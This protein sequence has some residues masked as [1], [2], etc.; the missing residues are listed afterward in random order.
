MIISPTVGRI[1]WYRDET[2]SEGQPHAAIVT[3]VHDDR[4]VN[5]CVFDYDGRPYPQTSVYLAQESDEAVPVRFCQWMPYQI[6]QAKKHASE[7]SK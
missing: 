4:L 3:F 7:D 6:G 1:V 5:L 2:V